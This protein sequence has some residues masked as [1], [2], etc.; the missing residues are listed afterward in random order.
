MQNSDNTLTFCYDNKHDLNFFFSKYVIVF[1]CVNVCVLFFNLVITI[2]Q[3][4]IDTAHRLMGGHAGTPGDAS[5]DPAS[6][7]E[8]G[9]GLDE[10]SQEGR[11]TTGPANQG[12]V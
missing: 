7:G 5:P 1:M 11:P 4:A 2:L 10:C 3:D 9:S 6:L 8:P 12:F